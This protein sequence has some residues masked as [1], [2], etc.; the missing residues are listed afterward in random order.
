[1]EMLREEKKYLSREEKLLNDLYTF[2]FDMPIPEK[3]KAEKEKPWEME[4]TRITAYKTLIIRKDPDGYLI[5]IPGRDEMVK[6]GSDDTFLYKSGEIL[7]AF[8]YDDEE[9][10]IYDLAGN[11]IR[12]AAGSEMKSFFTKQKDRMRQK[13]R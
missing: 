6:L 11:E 4:R 7:S 3:E 1:M 9:Y 13:V 2:Y 10:E 12:K 5:K 8:L